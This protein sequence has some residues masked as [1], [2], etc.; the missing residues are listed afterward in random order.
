MSLVIKNKSSNYFKSSS[1]TTLNN[2][3]TCIGSYEDKPTNRIYYFLH[4]N[5]SMGLAGKYDC[6]VEYDQ[7]N[8]KTFVVYQDGR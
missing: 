5:E 8:D 4:S 2:E 7:F 1:I 3:Y 6:I